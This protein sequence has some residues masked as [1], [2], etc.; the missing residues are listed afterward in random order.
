ME[1]KLQEICM[2][3]EIMAQ[4]NLLKPEGTLVIEHSKGVSY[5]DHP[6]IFDE[7][8]YGKVHFSFFSPEI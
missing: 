4:K 2:V 3:Q 5:I 6:H 7:R 1:I 8:R